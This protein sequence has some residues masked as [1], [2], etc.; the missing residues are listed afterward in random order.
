MCFGRKA[1]ENAIAIS[2]DVLLGAIVAVGCFGR[3]FSS[4]LGGQ[5]VRQAKPQNS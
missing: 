3:G 4:L 5:L 2:D 1:F